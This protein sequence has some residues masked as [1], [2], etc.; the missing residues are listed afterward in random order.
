MRVLGQGSVASWLR[1][2]LSV[3]WV[4]LWI[5]AAAL[6]L[7]AAAYGV[8]L[9]L[10][11]NGAV[12]AEILTGGTGDIRVGAGGGVFN[13]TYDEPGGATW[14]VVVPALLAGGVVIGGAL[15]IVHRLR[16]LFDSFT[17]SEP[18]RRE[19]ADHL[20]VIWI[21]MVV[22]ELSRFALVALTSALLAA[23]GPPEGQEATLNIQIDLSTWASILILIVLSEV[24]R[25][26]ARMREEQEL[27]I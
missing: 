26:G 15:V 6:V 5:A 21:T 25:E 7:C 24:F 14:P 20:R 27:T 1:L 2:G 16:K 23:F 13:V 17:S 11:A 19:N 8:L 18:F 10:V 12:S 22:V 9:A 4:V 3:I